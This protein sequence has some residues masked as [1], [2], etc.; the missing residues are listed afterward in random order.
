MLEDEARYDNIQSI[1]QILNMDY[2]F[3]KCTSSIRTQIINQTPQLAMVWW[4]S[5]LLEQKE[6]GGN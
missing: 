3:K 4:E 5:H 1:K 6:Q 2:C